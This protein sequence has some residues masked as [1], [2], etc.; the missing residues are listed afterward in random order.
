MFASNFPGGKYRPTSR[1][2]GANG[3][4]G[5]VRGP[6]K[7]TPRQPGK[8][9]GGDLAV[10]LV[11]GRGT[12]G[13]DRWREVPLWGFSW[14]WYLHIQIIGTTSSVMIAWLDWTKSYVG[15]GERVR[16]CVQ[17]LNSWR[18][19]VIWYENRLTS[20]ATTCFRLFLHII[21]YPDGHKFDISTFFQL[22]IHNVRLRRHV[23]Q[24][25]EQT[26][27]STSHK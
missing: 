24:W 15:E 11:W 8:H 12:R 14:S 20:R 23:Q 1:S 3:C 5:H 21:C 9:L 4:R 19:M 25:L 26:S 13:E 27:K 17:D 7:R 2:T 16:V 22:K 10:P 18:Q 6:W